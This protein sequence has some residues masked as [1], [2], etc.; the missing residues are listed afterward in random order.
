[1]NSA[2]IAESGVDL[3]G[4]IVVVAF[5]FID[6]IFTFSGRGKVDADD[7]VEVVGV[8]NDGIGMLFFVV[9]V[10]SCDGNVGIGVDAIGVGAGANLVEVV[11]GSSLV[12]IDSVLVSA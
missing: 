5:V 7:V 12:W 2:A 6:E 9:F 3:V 11:F 1:M 10:G 8:C 4:F